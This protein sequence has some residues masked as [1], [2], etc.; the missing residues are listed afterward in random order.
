MRVSLQANRARGYP[1]GQGID[2][3]AAW[4]DGRSVENQRIELEAASDQGVEPGRQ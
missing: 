1:A 3:V 2:V 4:V